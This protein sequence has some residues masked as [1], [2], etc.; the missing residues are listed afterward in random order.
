MHKVKERVMNKRT[1]SRYLENATNFKPPQIF[2]WLK[3]HRVAC[4]CAVLF[5]FLSFY[6][7]LLSNFCPSLLIVEVLVLSYLFTNCAEQPV[8]VICA[9]SANRLILGDL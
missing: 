5:L 2:K 3:F 8:I 1:K 6:F 7:L 9:F 4:E